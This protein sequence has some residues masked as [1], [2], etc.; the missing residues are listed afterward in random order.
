M[1]SRRGPALPFCH[2]RLKAQKPKPPKYPK[3]LTTLGD[4]IRLRRLDLGLL[5]REAAVRIGV[6]EALIYNWERNRASPQGH[7]LPG[8]IRFL[9]YD[10]HRAPRSFSER[11]TAIR[12]TLGLSQKAMAERLGIDTGT[13]RNCE[14]GRRS[15][16]K[17]LQQKIG[18]FLSSRDIGILLT[19]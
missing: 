16:S 5:Q 14:S 4:H 11:L 15:P 13:L 3:T 1:R 6:S 17:R 7:Q 9:G 18:Y 2:V 19:V 8:V 12:R 10:P